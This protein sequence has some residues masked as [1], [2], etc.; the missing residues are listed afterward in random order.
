M[1]PHDLYRKQRLHG[2]TRADMLV[3]LY[4]GALRNLDAALTALDA[5]D[6]AHLHFRHKSQRIVNELFCGLDFSQGEV[7]ARLGQLCEFVSHCLADGSKERLL[8]A[9]K[10]LATLLEAYQGIRDEGAALEAAGRIPRVDITPTTAL[11]AEA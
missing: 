5:G 10:V 7:P 9:R 1:T 8:G 2:W 6:P 11:R 3:E 4:R